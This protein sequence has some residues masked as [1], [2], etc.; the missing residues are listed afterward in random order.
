MKSPNNQTALEYW[1][2]KQIP[3]QKNNFIPT[4]GKITPDNSQIEGIKMRISKTGNPQSRRSLNKKG[5]LSEDRS[6]RGDKSNTQNKKRMNSTKDKRQWL[7]PDGHLS[8]MHARAVGSAKEGATSASTTS[9]QTNKTPGVENNK[10]TFV[11]HNNKIL[12]LLNKKMKINSEIQLPVNTSSQES[13]KL[14]LIKS[15]SKSSDPKIFQKKNLNNKMLGDSKSKNIK[16]FTK[17]LNNQI[18]N[19]KRSKCIL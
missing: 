2:S 6:K 14:P 17:F 7:V 5:N 13:S 11:R 1:G 16:K 9:N 19:T 4:V 15:N 10:G 18:Y 3:V 8:K 12:D